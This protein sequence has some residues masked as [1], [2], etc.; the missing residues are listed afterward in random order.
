MTPPEITD[1]HCH[2]D[3]PDF[4]GQLNTIIANAAAAG[5]TRMVTICTKLR[6]EP[7]VRSIAEAYQPV[8]FAAGT[9]PMSASSEPLATTEQ[10]IEMSKHEKFVG[11]GETGLDYYYTI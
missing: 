8:Y 10:L 6:L 4:S 5:V 11:V 2:L 9:H 1:S 3:F 7:Q